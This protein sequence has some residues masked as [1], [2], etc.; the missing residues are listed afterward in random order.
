MRAALSTRKTRAVTRA[1]S[2]FNGSVS[3]KGLEMR[4]LHHPERAMERVRDQW[5]EG[6]ALE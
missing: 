1:R 2:F 3:R 5:R 6:I 4:S